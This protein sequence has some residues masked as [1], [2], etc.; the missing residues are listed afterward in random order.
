MI[1]HAHTKQFNAQTGCYKIDIFV[2]GVYSCSTDQSKTCE[3]AK[4]R[5]LEKHPE[6]D[7]KKVKCNFATK[8]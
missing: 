8:N 5:F 3:K 4:I 2:N 7:A 6:L 1:A